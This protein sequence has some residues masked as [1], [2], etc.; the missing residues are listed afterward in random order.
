MGGTYTDFWD[1]NISSVC[2]HLW[3]TVMLMK[4]SII[5]DLYM[6]KSQAQHIFLWGG[7]KWSGQEQAGMRRSQPLNKNWVKFNPIIKMSP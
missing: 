2:V 4:T 1:Y 5:E 6:Q 3:K 7:R